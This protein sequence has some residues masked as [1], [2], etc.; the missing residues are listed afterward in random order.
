MSELGNAR[1][2]ANTLLSTS[3]KTHRR[4]TEFRRLDTDSF[5]GAPLPDVPAHAFSAFDRGDLGRATAL[6]FQFQEAVRTAT[7]PE[8]GLDAAVA[9]AEREV[10]SGR[11][12]ALVA[13]ALQLFTAHSPV[14]RQLRLHRP[15]EAAAG[16]LVAANKMA[17]ARALS[18]EEGAAL[19]REDPLANDHHIHWHVVYPASGIPRQ[20]API[21]LIQRWIAAQ[22]DESLFTD[23]E[24]NQLFRY[25]NRHGEMFVY[26][27]QQ[28]LARYDAERL[29][30]GLDPIAPLDRELDGEPVAEGYDVDP[31]LE[32]GIGG[33]GPFADRPPNR[34]IRAEAATYLR[35]VRGN[36]RAA[37][38]AGQFA[39]AAPNPPVAIDRD[40]IGTVIEASLRSF[41]SGAD[42][43][44]YGDF[45]DAGHGIL[46][47]LSGD[48]TGIMRDPTHAIRDPVFWRW[49]RAIDDLNFLWQETGQKLDF[50][51]RPPV[52]LRKGSGNWSSPDIVLLAGADSPTFDK[53]EIARLLTEQW[54]TVAGQIGAANLTAT[55][56]TTLRTANVVLPDGTQRDIWHRSHRPFAY[57]VRLENTSDSSAAVTLRV[58]IA[59][60]HHADDRRRWMELDK[61][62][63]IV[64]ARARHVV[65]RSGNESEV[66]KKPVD[67]GPDSFIPSIDTDMPRCS[68][69]WPFP[70]LLP[71]GT[72]AGV[73][74][75]MLVCVTDAAIDGFASKKGCGSV[76]F[77]GAQD[78]DYPDRR[79]MGYPF[80][81]GWQD[82]IT[83]IAAGELPSI[84]GREFTI[85]HDEGEQPIA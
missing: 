24:L 20:D 43:R 59:P 42:P 46:A 53:A 68:C 73:P 70:L 82:T 9:I 80:H 14:G 45:H 18:P 41:R 62:T 52:F 47:S 39:R 75:S 4:V 13:H 78:Q 57:A 81:R 21:D 23:D 58:F 3:P 40:N 6:S 35:T 76:S 34:Q 67:H 66:V 51:D 17:A 8:T 28:M 65:V 27:H 64:P 72:T 69:G 50:A 11:D 31:T 2:R 30:L 37:I 5:P 15:I 63:T 77:C 22:G 12:P 74:Y 49:H 79:D 38:Q 25:Q 19:W 85:I 61:V 29:A 1:T 26:M 83:A 71:R 10:E 36:L 44:Y 84:A 33:S 48:I 7:T 32:P 55:L 56:Q 16:R 54:D 60:R